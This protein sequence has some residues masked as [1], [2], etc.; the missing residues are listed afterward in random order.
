[1]YLLVNPQKAIDSLAEYYRK[2]PN[3]LEK[4][5]IKEKI[6]ELDYKL[7]QSKKTVK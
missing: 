2:T 4:L 1:M 6:R 7:K 5:K 3:K